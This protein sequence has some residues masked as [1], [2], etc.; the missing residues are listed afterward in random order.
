M[1]QPLLFGFHVRSL[2]ELTKVL[3]AGSNVIELK[4]YHMQLSGFPLYE[5][6]GKEFH[7]HHKNA[8]QISKLAKKNHAQIQIHIPYEEHANPKEEIGICQTVPSHKETIF[9]RFK[10][11]EKLRYKYGIGKVVTM[12]AGLFRY[13]GE[14]IYPEEEALIRNQTFFSELEQFLKGNCKFKVGVENVTSPKN[15]YASLGYTTGQLTYMLQDTDQIGLTIDTGH[16]NLVEELSVKEL[17]S[18]FPVYN[19]HLHMNPGKPDSNSFKDDTHDF[20]G[21]WNL[22][23]FYNYAKAIRRQNIPI[24][25]EVSTTHKSVEQLKNYRNQTMQDILEQ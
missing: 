1:E 24:I 16:R 22:P 6:D 18:K 7:I 8:K 25:C 20:A 9:K 4:P 19:L 10:L 12:H 15:T 2:D 3:D 17:M 13:Q 11:I 14:V 21:S 23:H 5:Y